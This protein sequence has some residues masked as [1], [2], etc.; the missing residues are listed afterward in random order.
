MVEYVIEFQRNQEQAAR[1]FL[2][3]ELD[4]QAISVYN[5]KQKQR[6]G[7][8]LLIWKEVQFENRL[9]DQAAFR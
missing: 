4:R 5:D 2:Y 7:F 8:F 3:T 1:L 6:I 9:V